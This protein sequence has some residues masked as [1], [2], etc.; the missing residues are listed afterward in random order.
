MTRLMDSEFIFR[1]MVIFLKERGRMV[2][3]MARAR[4]NIVMGLLLKGCLNLIKKK[5]RE[6][7]GGQM[8]PF[9]KGNFIIIK[10]QEMFGYSVSF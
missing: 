10:E 5:E 7:L 3:D 1:K 4:R 2:C 8:V 6:C 9:I